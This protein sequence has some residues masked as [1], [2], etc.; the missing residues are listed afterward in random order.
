MAITQC[1]NTA[2]VQQM[3][4]FWIL[5]NL[6]NVNKS[7]KPHTTHNTHARNIVLASMKRSEKRRLW[8]HSTNEKKKF[9]YLLWLFNKMQS[10]IMKWTF[11]FSLLL[12]Q[13]SF[14]SFAIG[15]D[16]HCYAYVIY[17]RT[18]IHYEYE[19]FFALSF[20]CSRKKEVSKRFTRWCPS[21]FEL[22]QPLWI[23]WYLEN[24]GSVFAC[25]CMQYACLTVVQT[26]AD[27]V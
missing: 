11:I 10:K 3:Q 9:I 16:L 21:N 27:N 18:P 23:D 19:F 20:L 25:N 12:L 15:F 24:S 1:A 14:D 17:S 22:T 8:R 5:F 2:H 26:R 13:C 4:L 6:S 7:A